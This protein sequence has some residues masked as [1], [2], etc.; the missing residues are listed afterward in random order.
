MVPL[1]Y[2]ALLPIVSSSIRPH[3]EA[4]GDAAP[5][6]STVSTALVT[7][8]PLL[9]A[10]LIWSRALATRVAGYV[11][12]SVCLILGFGI[13]VTSS[14]LNAFGETARDAGGTPG[15]TL[16]L[17][18]GAIASALCLLPIAALLVADLQALRR[19]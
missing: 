11:G 6:L 19:P 3:E 2:L 7:M 4:A 18:G 16:L 1:P 5:V 8:V 15:M 9:C 14:F 10:A 17:G 12:Y 13:G